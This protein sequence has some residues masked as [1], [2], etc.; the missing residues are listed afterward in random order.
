VNDLLDGFRCLCGEIVAVPHQ[1]CLALLT[2]AQRARWRRGQ[3]I[4]PDDD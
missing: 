4:G 2:P 1:G 3:P